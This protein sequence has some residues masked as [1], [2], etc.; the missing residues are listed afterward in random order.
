MARN[1]RGLSFPQNMVAS[2]ATIPA[3]VG[4]LNDRDSIANMP[5]TDAVILDNWWPEPSKISI[6]Q[7]CV[8]HAS[9]FPGPVDSII[10]YSP[11][12]GFV[13]LFAASGGG[14]YDITSSGV[15]GEPVVDD[16]VNNRWQH[17]SAT[18]LGGSFLYLFNGADHALL[19]DGSEWKH[20]DGASEPSI[21]GIDT[22]RIISGCVFKNRL[23]LV[24]KNSLSLWYLPFVSIGGTAKELPMGTVFQRGGYIS[25]I[26]SWTIDAG[27]GADD[28]F[29]IISSNGEVAVYSGTDPETVGAFALV[30]VFKFGRPVGQRCGIKFGGDLLILCE[31][32]VFPLAQAL[33]TASIDRRV[34]ITDKIQNSIHKEVRQRFNSFGWELCLSPEN[35]AIMLNVPSGHGRSYQYVQNTLTGAWTKFKGWNA[36]TIVNSSL[37]VYYGGQDAVYK[38]WQ[39]NLDNREPI[40]ADVLQAFN[41]FG[42]TSR[43]KLFTM[44]RPYIQTSGTPAILFGLNG[45]FDPQ[46]PVGAL[47]YTQPSGMVW[48]TMVW[49]DMVW[50][51]SLR[52]INAWAT[53]GGVYKSAAVRLKIQG[54]GAQVDW[55]ATDVMYT[56][57]GLL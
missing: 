55:A 45:D 42:S 38:A 13:K 27:A 46:E 39:G 50:G 32:G 41:Y 17:V 56:N 4:G 11:P 44:V 12:D 49:G 54:N 6:R 22:T 33:L 30:G 18:T 51:G 35:S 36:Q 8:E 43:T 9:G 23:Y 10:E 34:A 37:G 2:S 53:V 16:L 20:I 24:E 14:V 5:A 21:I 1:R 29:V 19:Y 52:Q 40:V 7:G 31:D 25:A 26:F 3:P 47:A 15:I 57:G 28:H 48:G